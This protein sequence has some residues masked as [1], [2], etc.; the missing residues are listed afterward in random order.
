MP[1][2]MEKEEEDGAEE[3][4][5]LLCK[6]PTLH[7]EGS[8]SKVISAQTL[9]LPFLSADVRVAP[10]SPN[11]SAALLGKGGRRYRAIAEH[12][13]QQMEATMIHPPEQ[14]LENQHIPWVLIPNSSSSSLPTLLAA[15]PR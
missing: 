11:E 13:V 3:V 2:K 5:S 10:C 8:M 6:L 7:L 15:S 14:L 1:W 4:I 12:S 9:P